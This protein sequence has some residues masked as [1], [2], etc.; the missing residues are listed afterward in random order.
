MTEGIAQRLYST[1]A[2]R[3]QIMCVAGKQWNVVL[4]LSYPW[5]VRL[6]E[7][8]RLIATLAYGMFHD[9]LAFYVQSTMIGNSRRDVLLLAIA[10]LSPL[11]AVVVMF[12]TNCAAQFV[13]DRK[14]A[15]LDE[16]KQKVSELSPIW[17]RNGE[18]CSAT[19]DAFA[20]Q[21]GST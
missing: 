7:R 13:V 20:E 2:S 17:A 16:L 10:I 3:S 9:H 14:R 19:N 6:A 1:Q 4:T 21:L 8:C 11:A 18:F 12:L 15:D 5:L